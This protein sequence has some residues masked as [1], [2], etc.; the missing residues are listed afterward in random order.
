[1]KNLF[2]LTGRLDRKTF[3]LI[4][5]ALVAVGVLLIFVGPTLVDMYRGRNRGRFYDLNDPIT[6]DM[7]YTFWGYCAM[8]LGLI[9]LFFSIKRMRDIDKPFWYIL[10]PF[11]NIYVLLTQESKS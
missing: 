11:Y 6:M 4:T 3:T 8:V 2:S 9:Y 10:I 7:A 1:M 5:I